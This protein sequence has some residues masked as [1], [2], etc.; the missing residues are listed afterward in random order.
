M[1]EQP[2]KELFFIT[3]IALL[4]SLAVYL[5]I[6]PRIAHAEPWLITAY[7]SDIACCGKADGIT[8]SGAKA[9]IGTA[10][11]NWLPFGTRIYIAGIGYFTIQD[12]G[13]K[14]LFGT[15]QRHIK[16]IDI[17]LPTHR[18]ARRFGRQYHE[19]RILP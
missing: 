18:R 7:T 12:H 3:L 10:A 15:R 4:F 16:H 2:L 14:S 5:I 19:V 17:W 1:E 8:A 6:L 9:G 11:C 13:A